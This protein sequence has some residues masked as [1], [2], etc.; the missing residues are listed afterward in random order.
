M[1]ADSHF[2]DALRT[3]ASIDARLEQAR[4]RVLMAEVARARRDPDAAATHV[5]E[6]IATFEA[7]GLPACA[8]RARRLAER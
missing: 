8:A 2:A 1:D 6:A 3:F 4:T 7:L 5:A